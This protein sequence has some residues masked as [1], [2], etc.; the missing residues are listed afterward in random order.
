VTVDHAIP[1]TAPSEN[2]AASSLLNRSDQV[3]HARDGRKETPLGRWNLTCIKVMRVSFSKFCAKTHAQR[4]SGA[5]NWQ[6]AEATMVEEIAR[7][8]FSLFAVVLASFL[9]PNFG[10][11]QVQ[12][13][14]PAQ[15][16]SSVQGQNGE[17]KIVVSGGSDMAT[18]IEAGTS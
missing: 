17:T 9:D 16:P 18:Y 4:E 12:S 15:T 8:A 13:S 3:G 5:N 10:L 7:I 6:S 11:A 14:P 2:T 1:V